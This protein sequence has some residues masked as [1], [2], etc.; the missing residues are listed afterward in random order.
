[1]SYWSSLRGQDYRTK[2]S[3]FHGSV[4]SLLNRDLYLAMGFLEWNAGVRVG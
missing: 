4:F 3:G 1:M 2:A